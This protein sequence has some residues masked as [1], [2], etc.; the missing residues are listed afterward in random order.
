MSCDV[1]TQESLIGLADIWC[2]AEDS[3]LSLNCYECGGLF[4]KEAVIRT[5]RVQPHGSGRLFR[6]YTKQIITPQIQIA[7]FDRHRRC[8]HSV[9][10]VCISHVWDPMVSAAN[11][12]GRGKTTPTQQTQVR[13]YIVDAIEK[14]SAGLRAELDEEFEIWFDYL[15][16]PQWERP[17][18]ERIISAIPDIFHDAE[19]TL[20]LL[21]DVDNDTLNLLRHGRTQ[22]ERLA[23]VTSVC[24][25][26]W[27]KRVWTAMEYV[28]SQKIRIMDGHYRV[29]NG[30]GLSLLSEVHEVWNKEVASAPSVHHIEELADMG[31]NIV[32][33][34][35]G[36]LESSHALK[37]LDFGS[38]FSLLSRRGCLDVRDFFTALLGIVKGQPKQPLSQDPHTDL[39]KAYNDLIQIAVSCMEAGD[40]SPVLMMP[41]TAADGT[42]GSWHATDAYRRKMANLF[43]RSGYIDVVAYGLGP[44]T[45]F[46]T[47]HSESNFDTGHGS[48][49]LKLDQLGLVTFAMSDSTDASPRWQFLTIAQ[50]VLTFTGPHVE[51]FVR[52]VCSRLFIL[53]DDDVGDILT[54]I[55]ACHEIHGILVK[56]YN[57]SV[58]SLF[59]DED[60]ITTGNRL[61]HLLGLDR[62]LPE[63]RKFITPLNFMD[64]HGG[65]LHNGNPGT[66][67]AAQCPG[68]KEVHVYRAAIFQAPSYVYRSIAYRIPGV[69]H[70]NLSTEAPGIMVKNREIVG[71]LIWASPACGCHETGFVNVSLSELPM[72]SPRDM[73]RCPWTA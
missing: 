45:G 36:P 59:D 60:R 6:S 17:S 24:N 4:G 62:T 5:F 63:K 54:N 58:P 7:V 37:V 35:L 34:N 1:E 20:I 42:A 68:C 48:M 22:T 73:E 8:V 57:T 2:E 49:R 29:M 28:R 72:R 23:G 56:W 10:Y 51:K 21:E 12:Q 39:E 71:R 30:V 11:Y 46:P 16:V 69:L 41:R 40:Y 18:K 14:I 61:A 15:S 13:N 9:R 52:T 27:F 50:T 70:Q 66:L 19:F 32:P 44:L 33:W 64:E 43:E 38:A 65:T 3:A 26:K 47:Y 25:A 31:N 67:I 53:D 55:N